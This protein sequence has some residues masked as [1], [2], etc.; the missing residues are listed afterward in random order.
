MVLITILQCVSLTY[1][2]LIKFLRYLRCKKNFLTFCR[3]TFEYFLK[4]KKTSLEA[5]WGLRREKVMMEDPRT[6]LGEPWDN[7][8]TSL[9]RPYLI[10]P[11]V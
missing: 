3:Q 8:W 4:I 9:G 1:T 6:T 10:C 11:R 2:E 5:S 7:L